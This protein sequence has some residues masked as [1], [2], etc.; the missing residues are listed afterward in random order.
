[1]PTNPKWV[2]HTERAAW[3]T[4]KTL[5]QKLEEERSRIAR[6]SPVRQSWSRMIDALDDARG[7][8]AIEAEAYPEILE[9]LI[10]LL[11]DATRVRNEHDRRLDRPPP[12]EQIV[13]VVPV[14]SQRRD[15]SDDFDDE[16]D[17]YAERVHQGVSKLEA[18]DR[19]SKARSV[20]R[21]VARAEMK[22]EDLEGA[23]PGAALDLAV[24]V[25][26]LAL[27]IARRRTPP[28]GR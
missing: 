28:R 12:E 21:L 11:D 24:E 19:S 26:A 10:T 18:P 27:A 15:P 1:M 16:I 7:R 2:Q 8:H 14:A 6:L 13:Q 4:V 17:G 23:E 9:R 20:E 22:L 25:G 3:D 5:R